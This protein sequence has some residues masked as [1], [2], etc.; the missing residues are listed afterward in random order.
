MANL[1]TRLFN[2]KQPTVSQP[3]SQELNPG[4]EV[5]YCCQCGAS[6]D[7]MYCNGRLTCRSCTVQYIH[8]LQEQTTLK[9]PAPKGGRR[10]DR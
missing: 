4:T 5:Y 2:A 3:I 8:R 9:L 1:I 6:H 10:H 7:L